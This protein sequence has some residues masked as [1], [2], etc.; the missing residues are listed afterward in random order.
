MKMFDE[1]DWMGDA[2]KW[3]SI[4]DHMVHGAKSDASHLA[5]HPTKLH[6]NIVIASLQHTV[7]E[8]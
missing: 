8:V 4:A 7:S 2:G 5:C 3:R 1:I 6:N